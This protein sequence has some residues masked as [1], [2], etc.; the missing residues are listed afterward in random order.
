MSRAT[1]IFNQALLERKQHPF[2]AGGLYK[3]KEAADRLHRDSLTIDDLAVDRLRRWGKK[4]FNGCTREDK[5][6][7]LRDTL[8]D[9]AYR[10]GYEI[11]PAIDALEQDGLSKKDVK[12]CKDWATARAVSLLCQIDQ[13]YEQL[14]GNI[15]HEYDHWENHDSLIQPIIDRAVIIADDIVEFFE[16]Q[17]SLHEV[18]EELI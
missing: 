17:T 18:S 14:R 11:V 9:V 5:A 12:L 7:W 8:L 10:L 13:V 2:V 16:R 4:A 3:I 6:K 15:K 1:K